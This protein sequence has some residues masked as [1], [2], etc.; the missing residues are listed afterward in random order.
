MDCSLGLLHPCDFPGKSTG[1]GCHFLLQRIFPTQGSNPG[2]LHCRQTLYHLSH[3]GSL[4]IIHISMASCL[5]SFSFP[6]LLI[7]VLTIFFLVSLA[8]KFLTI[9]F[10]SSKNQL[11]LFWSLLLLFL[12]L[13]DLFM[14]WSFK[15]LPTNFGF[16]VFFF[17]F[18]SCF[19]C[20][21][22]FFIWYF[23]YFLS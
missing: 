22:R 18:S 8:K 23:S 3:Q 17:S 9:L 21:D 13:F 5:T 16:C 6:V 10:I 1:V 14:L 20:E 7:W 19:R 11:L 15:F 2:L 12:S 4:M